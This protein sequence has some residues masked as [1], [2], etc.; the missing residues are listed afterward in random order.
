MSDDRL[1]V[2]LQISSST[3]SL[4][5]LLM[6]SMTRHNAIIVPVEFSRRLWEI[7]CDYFQNSQAFALSEGKAQAAYDDLH[8]FN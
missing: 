6:L 3:S 5:V 2:P 4:P 7:L 1:R 8:D